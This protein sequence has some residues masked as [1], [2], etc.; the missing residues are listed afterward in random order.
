MLCSFVSCLILWYLCMY[1]SFVQYCTMYIYFSLLGGL[2]YADSYD[3][4]I[5]NKYIDGM[6]CCSET[7]SS[8]CRFW[9]D[10][11]WYPCHHQPGYMISDWLAHM[12]SKTKNRLIT[13]SLTAAGAVH[14]HRR[15]VTYWQGFREAVEVFS[16]GHLR[17]ESIGAT[18]SVARQHLRSLKR[19]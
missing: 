3:T 9:L 16:G 7:P 4:N 11:W 14:K 1:C 13:A 5:C 18:S 19:W 8:H 6:T 12:V 17:K 2:T 15:R 10:M